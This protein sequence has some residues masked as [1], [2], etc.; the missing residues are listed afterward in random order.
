MD[1]S[2]PNALENS[3]RQITLQS[4]LVGVIYGQVLKYRY[5]NTIWL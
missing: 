3:A 1:S 5:Y 4:K 2:Y